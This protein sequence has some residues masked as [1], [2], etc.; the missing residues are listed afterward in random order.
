M[1]NLSVTRPA[2]FAFLEHSGVLAFAHRGGAVD[3]PENTMAAFQAAVEMG[4]TYLETDA[5]A[6][7]DG[8]LLSFH[9]D[10]LDRVTNHQGAIEELDY[11]AVKPARI[12]GQE[13]I[14]LLE[15]LIAAFPDARFNI[16]PK[17]DAC[18]EPLIEAIKRTG[19]VERVCI[20]S[21]SDKRLQRMRDA[22]GPK[23]CTSLGPLGT[24]R[25]RFSAWGLPMGGFSAVGCAQIPVI[26]SG[27]TL[28][29]KS[30]VD[31]AHKAGLQVHIWTIDDPD[32]MNRLLDMGV[33]GLMTDRPAVLKQVLQER[34][35]WT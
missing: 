19:A 12:G 5:Y 11:A 6:T 10:R 8:V 3:F 33:D 26:Q 27:F 9:D 14:P 29:N 25:L 2:K 15:D 23:L 24:A 7:R 32:E 1:T 17:H 21:F 13:P 4:F 22:L 28:G 20:G 18:V 35:L 30:M 34:G 16:D 31:R